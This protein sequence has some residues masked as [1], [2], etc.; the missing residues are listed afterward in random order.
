MLRNQ[1]Q[2]I[3]NLGKDPEVKNL[4]SGKI[5]ATLNMATHEF[6]TD[7]KGERVEKTEWHQVVAWGN[8]AKVVEKYLRKGSEVAIQGKLIHRSYENKEGQKKYVTEVVANEL[9]LLGKADKAA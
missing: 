6:Y 4:E 2:L 3:G 7:A 8:T 1:V 5:M 9:V